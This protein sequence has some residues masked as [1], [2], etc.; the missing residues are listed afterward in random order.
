MILEHYPRPDDA[1]K[2]KYVAAAMKALNAV[3]LV[4]MHNAGT[5]PGTVNLL[6][7][8]AGGEDW[9]VRMYAMR[10]CADRNTFCADDAKKI[11]REDG[12]LHVRSVKLFAG[13]YINIPLPHRAHCNIFVYSSY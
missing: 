13:K 2:T 8:L 3:G 10:E 12:M 11:E 4:G 6:S 9:T 5:D 7:R 1:M